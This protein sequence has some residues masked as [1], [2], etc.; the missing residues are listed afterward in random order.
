MANFVRVGLFVLSEGGFSPRSPAAAVHESM[1]SFDVNTI[2]LAATRIVGT[3]KPDIK[4][5]SRETPF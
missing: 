5:D 1:S 4:R 2:L 3:L